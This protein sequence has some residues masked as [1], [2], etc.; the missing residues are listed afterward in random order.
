MNDILR[1]SLLAALMPAAAAAAQDQN[2]VY[3]QQKKSKFDVKVDVLTRQEWTEEETFV[4]TS[5]RHLRVRPRVEMG[6]GPVEVGI[7][8]AF[9]Y[10][11]DR[12]INPPEGQA[13][14]ALLRDNYKSRDVR[15]DLA[16]AALKPIPALQ[17][18][19][20]RFVMP[21]RFTEMIWDRDLRPQGA[22]AT[23][24][25]SNLG[26]FARLTVTGLYA[27]G[28]HIL[29]EGD[30]FR[31]LDQRDRMLVG[32][33]TV[34]FRSG[35]TNR[36]DITG[37]FVKFDELPFVDS[38]IRRQNTRQS[39]NL[40]LPYEV[41]DV[42][43]RYR[44]EGRVNTQ[45]VANYCWNRAVD[46]NNRGLWLAFLVGSTDT[47]RGAMEYTYAQVDKDA[48]LAAYPTDDFVWQTGW[49][50]HRLDLGV[51]ISDRASSHL[52]G[53]LQRFKDS[54]VEAA[55]EKWIGRARFELRLTY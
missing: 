19:A 45:L 2:N 55:R 36:L 10:G 4:D 53:Q 25:L 46:D 38:R 16:W 48:T 52:V 9:E 28:S 13:T 30:P 3:Q 17:F 54:P 14:L 24:D 49:A 7:G 41:F 15:L 21:V 47:A 37:S 39:G 8:G 12:N 44:A 26:P 42:V 23:L 43:A 18:Q 1:V 40:V 27:K 33:A 51:R 35:R 6:A 11:S 32:S 31:D 34:S 5:R 22:A 20:G 29:P 50:G